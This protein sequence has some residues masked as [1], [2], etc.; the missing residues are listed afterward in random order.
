MKKIFIILAMLLLAVA[1]LLAAGCNNKSSGSGDESEVTQ[2]YYSNDS[3]YAYTLNDQNEATVVAY[4]GKASNLVLNRIDGRQKIVAIG[5][6]VFKENTYLKSVE[7][8]ASIKTIGENA[9]ASCTSLTSVTFRSALGSEGS[10]E[11]I[12]NGA[13]SGCKVLTTFTIPSTVKTIG[14]NAFLNCYKASIDFSQATSL[15]TIG[16]YAFSSCG[17]N[18]NS[19][20][21]VIL[22][23][24]LKDLGQGAFYG[25][26]QITSFEVADGNTVF[27][28]RDGILYNADRTELVLYPPAANMG[29]SYTIPSDVRTIAGSAFAGVGLKSII[30]PEGLEEIGGSAFYKAYNLESIQI[31][32]SVKNIGSYAFMACS[33]LNTVN[34]PDFHAFLSQGNSRR[35]FRLLFCAGRN[36]DSRR[37]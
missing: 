21:N 35:S 33:A 11:S 20:T 28:A 29:G 12:G 32:S 16:D 4:Y 13:F 18:L 15:E 10:L 5:N 1:V 9:F 8:S 34:I 14:E 3:L 25:C 7:L 2:V 27:S 22:P 26:I 23:A 37:C 30:L 6:N 19:A 24:S 17:M 31:P 36:Y